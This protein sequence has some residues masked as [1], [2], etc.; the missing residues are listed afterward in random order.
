[1][2]INNTTWHTLYIIYYVTHS[3]TMLALV[4]FIT[5][6]ITQVDFPPEGVRNITIT[7][8]KIKLI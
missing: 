4:L 6:Q 7:L 3:D 2:F 5:E 8:S 1:M